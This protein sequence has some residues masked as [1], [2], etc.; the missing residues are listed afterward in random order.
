[1][2]PIKLN[3]PIS[4]L[5]D[6]LDRAAFWDPARAPAVSAAPFVQAA[7]MAARQRL[8]AQH[9]ADDQIGEDDKCPHLFWPVAQISPADVGQ[10][11]DCCSG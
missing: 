10:P 6:L 5:S 7:V 9:L 4:D 1:L 11:E 3:Q 2:L 8:A